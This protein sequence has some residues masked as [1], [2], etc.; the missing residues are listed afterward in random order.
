MSTY[1]TLYKWRLC[2]KDKVP[3]VWLLGKRKYE[4]VI[5]IDIA[6]LPSMKVTYIPS[7]AMYLFCHNI[8]NWVLSN[9]Q[10]CQSD[11]W[12]MYLVVGIMYISLIMSESNINVRAICISFPWS[13]C[14]YSFIHFSIG[15]F[16]LFLLICRQ[17][18]CIREIN[19]LCYV[20]SLCCLLIYGIW[21]AEIFIFT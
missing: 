17:S 2:L 9:F 13:Y 10:I 12:K 19:P 8:A 1:A 6:K 7:G 16:V 14:A 15:F 3:K 20:S 18:L 5:L 11:R 4:F 21:H